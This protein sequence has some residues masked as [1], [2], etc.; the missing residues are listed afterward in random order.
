MEAL[1]DGQMLRSEVFNLR[2]GAVSN[3]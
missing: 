3:E 1:G 2:A